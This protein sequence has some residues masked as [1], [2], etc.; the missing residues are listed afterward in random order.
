MVSKYTVYLVQSIYQ[1]LQQIAYLGQS[2]GILEAFL[3]KSA[4]SQQHPVLA[5]PLTPQ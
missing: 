5:L 3:L 1:N 2:K 4:A